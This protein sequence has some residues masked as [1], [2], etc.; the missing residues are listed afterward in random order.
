MGGNVG[1]RGVQQRVPDD[2]R[3]DDALT[4]DGVEDGAGLVC[5]QQG[6]DLHRT[7][8][9]SDLQRRPPR[10]STLDVYKVKILKSCGTLL[11]LH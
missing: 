4:G 7:R 10:T 2:H 8:E 1:G 9:M 5:G 6:H 3:V 11:E